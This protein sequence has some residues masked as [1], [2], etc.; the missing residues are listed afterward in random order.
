MAKLTETEVTARL[1]PGWKI[2]ND[3]IV[4]VF[5]LGAYADHAAFTN[6]LA[7]IADRHDHHPDITLTYPSVTV[8]LSTH[9]EGGIT[10]K[11]LAMATEAETLASMFS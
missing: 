7:R 5:K 9:S 8:L 3:A 11:D 1:A 10:E 2:E 6:L 4:K